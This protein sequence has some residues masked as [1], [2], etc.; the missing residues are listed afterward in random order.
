MAAERYPA[1]VRRPGGIHAH[2]LGQP[3]H[4]GPVGVDDVDAGSAGL[5]RASH[6]ERAATGE[7]QRHRDDE[8][9]RRSTVHGHPLRA[10]TGPDHRTASTPNDLDA[11]FLLTPPA[12][13]WRTRSWRHPATRR[14]SGPRGASPPAERARS[15]RRSRRRGRR[16]CPATD[17]TPRPTDEPPK[18][19]RV[20]SGDQAGS[21]TWNSSSGMTARPEPSTPMMASPPIVAKASRAPSGDQTGVP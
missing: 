7:E 2:P 8:E 3:G 4:P 17:Q 11:T 19:I 12:A 20:P 1:A 21:I 9:R 6:G 13:R 18:A 15:R 5:V 10:A 14:G 16:R